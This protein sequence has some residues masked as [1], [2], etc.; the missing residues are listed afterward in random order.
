MKRGSETKCKRN[1]WP[2]GTVEPKVGT[3]RKDSP[4]N[5]DPTTGTGIVSLS[6]DAYI[7]ELGH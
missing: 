2:A 5:T 3:P 4:H 1:T 6:H 7:W